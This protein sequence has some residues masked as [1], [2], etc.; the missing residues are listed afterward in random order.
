MVYL[1]LIIIKL[2][3]PELALHESSRAVSLCRALELCSAQAAQQETGE[4]GDLPGVSQKGSDPL[5]GA[6][7]TPPQQS[8]HMG[9]GSQSLSSVTPTSPEVTS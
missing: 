9:R 7:G 6:A 3:T 8:L 5:G 4:R 1:S 2:V